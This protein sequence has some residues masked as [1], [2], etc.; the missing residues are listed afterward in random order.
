MAKKNRNS[1]KGSK[2]LQIGPN[3][4]TWL[5]MGPNEYKLIQICQNLKIWSGHF[6]FV[7]VFLGLVSC[8]ITMNITYQCVISEEE[9][10]IMNVKNT[11]NE[12]VMFK[13][14][15]WKNL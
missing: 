1:K 4:F 13:L 10:H 12:S 3:W 9:G 7:T 11:G 8:C 6:E 14:Y 5:Q 15:T 2:Q